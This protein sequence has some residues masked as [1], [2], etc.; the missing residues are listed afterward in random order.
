MHDYMKYWRI[1]RYYYM[2]K[3]KI[4]ESTLELLLYLYS[5]KYFTES[6]MYIFAQTL[7]WD[8]ARMSKLK[9]D[10]WIEMHRPHNTNSATIWKVTFKTKKL[11]A[12]LYNKLEGGP[13]S[14]N[15]QF[16]P[17]FKKTAGFA[18]KTY[19]NAILKMN[20][21]LASRKFSDD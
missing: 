1:V 14:E 11:V 16:N 9:K 19:K 21:E 13:I 20:K 10:G 18:H 2:T 4:S 5:E 17:L 6:S 7:V 15:Y 3:H 12:S 8:K